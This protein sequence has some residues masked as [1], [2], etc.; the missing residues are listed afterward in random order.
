MRP[1]RLT[2]P[3]AGASFGTTIAELDVAVA[4]RSESAAQR[5]SPRTA[6]APP[7]NVI[8]FIQCGTEGPIKIGYSAKLRTR[9]ADLQMAHHEQ[10]Y[11][12]AWVEAD[13]S[14]ER[15]LHQRFAKIRIRGEWFKPH[16]PVK[17]FIRRLLA[18]DAPKWTLTYCPERIALPARVF[19]PPP[20]PVVDRD[21][22]REWCRRCGYAV[23]G[24]LAER[25]IY[26]C[27]RC[28]TSDR[29]PAVTAE[30]A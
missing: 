25:S 18:D 7:R 20:L 27:Y 10:L 11:L 19:V 23:E 1:N 2:K 6:D 8:Y 13:Q 15:V 12:L 17:D 26:E 4:R 5:R 9:F 30:A 28:L 24:E 29:T 3:H 14:L 21:P 22:A 16:H